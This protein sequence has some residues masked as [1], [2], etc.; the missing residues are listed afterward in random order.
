MRAELYPRDDLGGGRKL[1]EL[2]R[3][4]HGVGYVGRHLAH[5]PQEHGSRS[6]AW[7]I[8]VDISLTL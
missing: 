4:R 2:D 1:P 5:R 6:N 3:A 7:A 8:G